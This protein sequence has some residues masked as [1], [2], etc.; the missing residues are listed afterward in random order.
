MVLSGNEGKMEEQIMQ[1]IFRSTKDTS[2]DC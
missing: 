1:S 2:E